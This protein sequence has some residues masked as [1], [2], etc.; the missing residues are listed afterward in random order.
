GPSPLP[1]CPSVH[2]TPASTAVPTESVFVR[3]IGVSR[4]PSSR[5]CRKP[6]AFPKPLPTKT[7][8]GAFSR[9]TLPSRGRMAVTPVR[10]ESPS[11]SVACPTRTPATS[12]IAFH[13][14]DGRIPGFTPRARMRGRSSADS[15]PLIPVHA[16]R[17]SV[18]VERRLFR[19]LVLDLPRRRR[20]PGALQ[21]VLHPADHPQVVVEPVRGRAVAV[22][23]LRIEHET[24][25][26]L[27]ALLQVPVEHERLRRMH[28]RIL[29]PVEDQQRRP[30]AVGIEDRASLQHELPVLPRPLPRVHQELLV[31]NV[32]RPGL[33]DEIADADEHD[34]G[35]EAVRVAGRA[36]RRRV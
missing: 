16:N 24:D 2:A 3:T 12:V 31:G 34:A 8:A 13:F 23:L 27:A 4:F 15:R 17:S 25:G 7:A 36:P 35:G 30:R 1:A 21:V 22:P 20:A 6:A 9:K 5:T 26:G 32:G 33:G 28:A 14:P 11:T 29:L 10:T 18:A 19:L